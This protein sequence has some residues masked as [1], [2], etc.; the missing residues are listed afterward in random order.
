MIRSTSAPGR[1]PILRATK[2]GAPYRGAPHSRVD[3]YLRSQWCIVWL[4]AGLAR[5]VPLATIRTLISPQ[6]P[7]G[8]SLSVLDHGLGR[9]LC[10]VRVLLHA[11]VALSEVPAKNHGH[12]ALHVTSLLASGHPV[13][14]EVLAVASSSTSIRRL[15]LIRLSIRWDHCKQGTG[16]KAALLRTGLLRWGARA[17]SRGGRSRA[18]GFRWPGFGC[19]S[20]RELG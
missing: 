9:R 17:A 6:V 1:N 2:S 15:L 10:G 4:P 7:A 19:V 11:H 16:R 14:V 20:Y 8:S 13:P 12:V 3:S 18:V 5:E